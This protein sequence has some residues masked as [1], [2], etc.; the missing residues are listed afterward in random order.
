MV[1]IFVFPVK[2]LQTIYSN[3]TSKLLNV[4]G[5][6]KLGLCPRL[7]FLGMEADPL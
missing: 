2:K 6:G 4:K 5:K 3:S 1:K 7:Y